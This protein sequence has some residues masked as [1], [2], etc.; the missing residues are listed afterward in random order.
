M[1]GVDPNKFTDRVS[2]IVGKRVPAICREHGHT[3]LDSGHAAIALLLDENS[4]GLRVLSQAGVS[5]AAVRAILERRVLSRLPKQVPAPLE[6]GPSSSFIRFLQNGQKHQA[7]SGDSFLGEH[8]LLASLSD[9]KT[10][11]KAVGEAGLSSSV[12]RKGLQKLAGGENRTPITSRTGD[13]NFDALSKYAIN[14][15]DRVKAGELDPVIGRDSE[16][17]RVVQILARRT[18]NNP[19][20]IGHPGVGKTA[21]VEGLAARICAGDVPDNIAGCQIWSLDMGALVAGAKYRGEFEERLKAVLA[22]VSADD[23]MVVLFIDEMHLLMGAGKTDGAMDAANLLK[24]LL[25]R[26]K[27]RCIGATTLMEHRKFVEKDKAFERRFQQVRVGEPDVESAVS[28]LRGLKERYETHHGVRIADA[29]LV[30]AVQLSDRYITSRFLPDKAID[31]VDEASAR[32]RVQLD[33]RPDQIDKLERRKMQLEIEASAL[34]REK[35]QASKLRLRDVNKELADVADELKPLLARWDEERGRVNELK[36]LKE[37]LDRLRQKAM[38]AR[39]RG[40]IQKASDVEYFAIPECEET[41]ERLS[42]QLDEEKTNDDGG[43]KLLAETVGV[44]QIASVVSVWTGIP[45]ARLGQT[46]KTRLLGLQK[47]ISE[48]VVGQNTA[49]RVVSEAI[50]RSR[51]GLA[52]PNQPTGSFLFL[53]PTGVGKTELA[54]SLATELFDTDKHITRI[55]MSEYMEKHS[56]SRLIGAPPGYVGHD[57]GGQLTEA[58]RRRPY[59]VVLFDEVEKAHPQVLN[60]LLQVLDDGRLTDSQGRVVD[61]SNVVVILTSNLGAEHILADATLRTKRRRIDGS[62]NDVGSLD[63]GLPEHV[64]EKVMG[65]VR[66]HFR[67]E[68]LNRLDEIVTFS[69]LRNAGLMKICKKQIGLIQSRIPAQHGI[70]LEL[71]KEA[72]FAVIKHSYDPAY[73]ARPL[74]RFMER[75][76]V[77][78]LSKLIIADRVPR[79]SL[80]RI[81]ARSGT[82][83]DGS[84][85]EDRNVG[86][87]GKILSLR[88]LPG[89][90][91]ESVLGTNDYVTAGS[92][93]SRGNSWGL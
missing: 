4:L 62:T 1:S 47:K 41:I 24:P 18:K 78:S 56:V 19:V 12:L 63:E 66:S 55:D 59:N 20:L 86:E 48:R 65:V 91:P 15:C 28:I 37:R 69:P 38:E 16:I 68:F 76:I 82:S 77:T 17:R 9:E 84:H 85:D 40:D 74:E 10:I 36:S 43:N 30:A 54:K 32:V 87:D 46:Q 26:G 64:Q 58:V 22:E 50:L 93:L 13:Q 31:L 75:E 89:P 80:V 52:R 88:I 57:E 73:G 71:T 79:N 44:D 49:V 21:I 53:G 2:E 67:P 33:S 7:K 83:N 6:V 45:V 23:S 34:G 8:H 5:E 70:Q 42:K 72:A 3:Q 60:I 90:S 11:M 14:L 61:F 39:R 81:E 25:A 51:A 35:D 29:A 92:P 27:L